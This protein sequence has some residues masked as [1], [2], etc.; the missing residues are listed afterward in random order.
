MNNVKWTTSTT[1][2]DG[3][4]TLQPGAQCQITVDLTDL[5]TGQT[6]SDNLT[7]NDTFTMQIKPSIGSTITVQRT[8][9]PSLSYVMDL[10]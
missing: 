4:D 3:T 9:P 1:G 2:G 7:A 10:N 5:G 8:L 6:L